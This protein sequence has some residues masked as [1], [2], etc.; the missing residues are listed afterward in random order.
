VKG[1]GRATRPLRVAA[2]AIV[3]ALLVAETVPASAAE[4]SPPKATQAQKGAQKG[5][6]AP[7]PAPVSPPAPT[8][9]P[10][11][12]Q[13]LRLAEMM[14]ALAYLRDL[15]GAG[16]SADFRARIAAL[17]DA[18]GADQQRR[19]LI[20]GAYNKGFRDYATNYRACGPSANAVIQ[21]YL[22][23]TARLAADIASRYGGG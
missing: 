16:D 23:E 1:C 13:I 6:A 2:A 15:C 18:E 19:D 7:A 14:G 20:A 3:A 8:A 17:L 21:H 9:P 10:Y 5:T 22:T 12:P 11:E 4:T